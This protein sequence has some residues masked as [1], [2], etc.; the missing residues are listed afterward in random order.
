MCQQTR[1]C[2]GL[3]LLTYLKSES[4]PLTGSRSKAESHLPNNDFFFPGNNLTNC[5]IWPMNVKLAE[6]ERLAAA[7][8]FGRDRCIDLQV[9]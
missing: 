5:V 2:R 7:D 8:G 3:Q 1:P 9:I 6:E 4:L